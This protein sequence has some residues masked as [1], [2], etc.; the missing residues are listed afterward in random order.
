MGLPTESDNLKNYNV[1]K[2]SLNFIFM[3]C[4]FPKQLCSL[5]N[6]VPSPGEELSVS[7]SQC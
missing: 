1:R 3:C 2:K 4:F 6:L 5:H 7:S